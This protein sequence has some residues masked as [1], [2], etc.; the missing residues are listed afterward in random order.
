MP[1]RLG[2]VDGQGF[3]IP[4]LVVYL[5]GQRLKFPGVGMTVCQCRLR[6]RVAGLQLPCRLSTACG[7]GFSRCRW[8]A[9]TRPA[10]GPRT[11]RT[12]WLHVLCDGEPRCS[13]GPRGDPWSDYAGIVMHNRFGP[14]WNRMGIGLCA[15]GASGAVGMNRWPWTK[16]GQPGMPFAFQGTCSA[17]PTE[18]GFRET[19][20][21]QVQS[22]RVEG[23]AR[24]PHLLT[25][26]EA[27]F[28]APGSV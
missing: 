21:S 10:C 26:H 25:E 19:R 13:P 15:A 12:D 16:C 27:A 1:C 28:F 22:G 18:A 3:G 5:D 6:G 7:R 17:E 20:C 9:W 4:F 24:N 11:V 14:D 23:F 2:V 8:P